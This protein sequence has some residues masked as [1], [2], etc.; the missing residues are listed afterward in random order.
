MSKI[1]KFIRRKGRPPRIKV[2][3][4][5]GTVTVNFYDGYVTLISSQ[6]GVRFHSQINLT[7]TAW[8]RLLKES[9]PM[10][11]LMGGPNFDADAAMREY[12]A[13][14]D[15]FQAERKAERRALDLEARR[16]RQQK[17][18]RAAQR[19]ARRSA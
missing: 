17:R 4:G 12:L 2:A 7:R 14:E 3:S 11:R 19:K 9:V 8:I 10:T 6:P 18:Y 16:L 13:A 1:G 5:K 15:L